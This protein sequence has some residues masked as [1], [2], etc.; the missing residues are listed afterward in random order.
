MR[1]LLVFSF[2]ALLSSSAFASD[3]AIFAGKSFD[4]NL[5]SRLE[6]TD[7]IREFEDWDICKNKTIQNVFWQE[8]EYSEVLKKTYVYFRSTMNKAYGTG[9]DTK[10]INHQYCS[11]IIRCNVD[12]VIDTF[13]KCLIKHGI[14]QED[15]AELAPACAGDI[16]IENTEKT[17]LDVGIPLNEPQFVTESPFV[18][19]PLSQNAPH[20]VNVGTNNEWVIEDAVGSLEIVG[21]PLT[22][23]QV[24]TE[25][26]FHDNLKDAIHTAPKVLSG[27][28]D[29]FNH[30]ALKLM[31][32]NS[33]NEITFRHLRSLNGE[34]TIYLA[35]KTL[36]AKPYDKYTWWERTLHNSPFK[37][38]RNKC[39]KLIASQCVMSQDKPYVITALNVKNIVLSHLIEFCKKAHKQRLMIKLNNERKEIIK[40][41]LELV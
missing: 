35:A 38:A 21:E 17:Q 25:V 8:L 12:V 1:K 32:L 2:L 11:N 33:E 20:S 28:A 31:G 30:I 36:D 26:S 5:E 22:N 41:S 4:K 24:K 9:I 7:L 13:R 27:R 23:E 29:I 37:W 14:E 15:V 34:L 19:E 18:N 10:I 6:S 39:R 40:L 16:V 3:G